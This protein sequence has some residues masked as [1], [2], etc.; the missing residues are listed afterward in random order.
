MTGAARTV[1]ALV[2]AHDVIVLGAGV[3][4]LQCARDLRS[5]GADVLVLD[6][7]DKP[8]GRCATRVFDGASAD[9]GP[10]FL[11]G[12]DPGFLEAARAASG[13]SIDGWPLRVEGKGKPCQPA[14]FAPG[15]TR[16]A[17]VEGV[18]A[19][20][21]SL[22][23]GLE[24]RLGFQAEW[25]EKTADGFAIQGPDGQRFE[26]RD[27][28]LALALEQALPFLDQLS[29]IQ[30]VAGARAL[31]RM[32][33]TVPC[34]AV[35]AGYSR[36]AS[37]PS[38]DVLYPDADEALMLIG[39]ESAKR[40]GPPVLVIQ[41]TPR[42]SRRHLEE[43]RETWTQLLLAAVGRLIG[44]WAAAPD[45]KHPHRWRFGRLD[46]ANELAAPLLLPLGSGRLG[47]CGDI[48][49][50]GGGVQAAWKSGGVL[51]SRL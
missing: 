38:W 45:W 20:P 46:S 31:L 23:A 33:G 1:Y 16:L 4:G 34:L 12:S 42:W 36:D 50:P 39:N 32:F 15:E 2:M 37:L 27:L 28:V 17:F 35:I 11:H 26:S 24:I 43:P 51:A 13:R 41:A 49:S 40:G 19:F 44:P 14:A 48:F 3:A 5:R 18:N 21:R 8:G 7:A 6:R 30:P 29:S 22:S 25:V 10:L 47:L 9:Y